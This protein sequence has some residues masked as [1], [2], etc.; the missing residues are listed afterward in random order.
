[1]AKQLSLAQAWIKSVQMANERALLKSFPHPSAQRQARI[2]T[3]D[4]QIKGNL[5][6]VIDRGMKAKKYDFE[7]SLTANSKSMY[8]LRAKYASHKFKPEEL[9]HY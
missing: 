8:R 2:K 5:G 3:L 4:R 1:M 7:K 9:V 6:I